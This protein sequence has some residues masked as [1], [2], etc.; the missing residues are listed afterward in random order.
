MHIVRTVVLSWLVLL[1]T[2]L[3]SAGTMAVRWDPVAGASGYKVYWGTTA[4]HYTNQATVTGTSTTLTLS[5]ATTW[6]VGVKAYNGRGESSTYSNEVSGLPRPTISSV[7]PNRG[8]V[9]Q[10][11]IVTIAGTNFRIGMTVG[12]L[13]PG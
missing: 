4:G 10:R 8:T 6:Y 9:G 5:D 1:L 3:A 7:T 12:F 11:L 2:P 13:N